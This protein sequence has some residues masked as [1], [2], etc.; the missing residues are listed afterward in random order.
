MSIWTIRLKANLEKLAQEMIQSLS[1]GPVLDLAMGGG[2]FVSLAEQLQSPDN[3]FGYEELESDIKYAKIKKKLRGNYI[4]SKPDQVMNLLTQKK[5]SEMN[6]VGNW[7]FTSGVGR[8]PVPVGIV[9]NLKKYGYPK[10]MA[11]ILQSGFLH[12]TDGGLSDLRQ[13]LFDAGLYKIKFNPVDLFKESGAKVRTVTVFCRQGYQ[14]PI[15]IVNSKGQ[16]QFDYRKYGYIIDGGSK[17]LT[18]F[19]INLRENFIPLTGF[20]TKNNRDKILELAVDKPKQGYIPFQSKM[21]VSGDIIRYAPAHLFY[22]DSSVGGYRVTAGYRPSGL[23]MGDPRIGLTSIIE[24][25]VYIMSSPNICFK[26]GQNKKDAQSLNYYLHHEIIEKFILPKTR[27]S[28][29]LDCKKKD[30]Q[31]KFLPKVPEGL[32]LNSTDDILKFLKISKK[33]FKEIQ[34]HY[35]Y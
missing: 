31:T 21:S 5:L 17:N 25:G 13:Y 4:P 14:G 33:L 26:V 24:P 30:G 8:S 7:P 23:E 10:S 6:I 19:L 28:P 32:Y 2:Q 27:T 11:V 22:S 1:K 35:E 3:V 12:T 9:R 29:T 15:T 18:D 34:D 16:Y 20:T